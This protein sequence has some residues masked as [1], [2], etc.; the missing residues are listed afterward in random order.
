MVGGCAFMQPFL[1]LWESIASEKKHCNAIAPLRTFAVQEGS[2]KSLTDAFKTDCISPLPHI[3]LLRKTIT[4]A[5][6]MTRTK[7][8]TL[9]ISHET[10]ASVEELAKKLNTTPAQIMKWFVE[11]SLSIINDPDQKPNLPSTLALLRGIKQGTKQE[12]LE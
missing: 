7:N 8:L 5:H 10:N 1:S 3:N 2:N 11:S 12:R 4:L 9:R 6:L